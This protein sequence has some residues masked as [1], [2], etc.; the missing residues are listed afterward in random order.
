MSWDSTNWQPHRSLMLDAGDPLRAT[1]FARCRSRA[2]GGWTPS[3]ARSG[4]AASSTAGGRCRWDTDSCVDASKRCIGPL[5]SAVR[6]SCT[7]GTSRS[8]KAT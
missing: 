6:S 3:I 2:R 4:P 5:A 8:R 7:P 1:T